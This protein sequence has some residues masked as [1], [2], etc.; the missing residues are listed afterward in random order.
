VNTSQ[1]ILAAIV[2]ING[3]AIGSFLNVVIYRIPAGLSVVSPPSRCPVCLHRLGAR[4]NIPILG[5][6][7][8]RGKCRHCGTPISPRYPAIE[9]ATALTFLAVYSQFGWS[10]QTLG[11]CLLM[12]WLIALSLIDLDTMTLPEPLTRS[13]IIVGLVYQGAAGY[14]GTHTLSGVADSISQ[15]V[16]GMLLG[17]WLY[18]GIQ[19]GGSWLFNRQAL[20]S[21]DAKLMAGIGMWLGWKSILFAGFS[22]SL[23]GTAVMG[24]M[25]GLGLLKPWQKFPFGPFL[26]FG[27]V[28]YL[29]VGDRL[30]N[31]Y[32]KFSQSIDP[33]T[34]FTLLI[35]TAIGLFGWLWWMRRRRVDG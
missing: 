10:I 28:L 5:W 7:L 23:L 14:F 25:M 29:F 19:F 18:D 26:A 17:I 21:G 4:E 9:L 11:Y 6:L 2:F 35:V 13:L 27:G 32:Q 20:G 22:A 8:L 15:G 33:Q 3:A 30:I 34:L 24:S 16:W 31:G 1:L 12:A